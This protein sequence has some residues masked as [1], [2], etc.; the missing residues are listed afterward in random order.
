ML[1]IISSRAILIPQILLGNFS[2][3][4]RYA[5]LGSSTVQIAAVTSGL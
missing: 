2:T 4:P 5:L 3:N 1:V